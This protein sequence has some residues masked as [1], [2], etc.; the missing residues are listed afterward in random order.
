[1]S[2][3]A[4]W[5]GWA[6][7]AR[8]TPG[9]LQ[10]ASLAGLP[11]LRQSFGDSS[12]LL[13]EVAF[14]AD[15]AAD[16][17]TWT[18]AD[19]TSDVMFAGNGV[20]ISPMGRGDETSASQP[21]GCRFQLFNDSGAYGTGAAGRHYPYVRRNTPVRVRVT[22]DGSSWYTRFQG[23][24]NGFTPSWD[25]SARVAVVSVSASGILRRLQQ[26][27][28]PLQS[29]IARTVL[30]NLTADT[31][32]E[33]W[34]CEE[35]GQPNSFAS[36]M[37]GGPS[38]TYSGS[39]TF[40]NFDDIPGS[41]PLPT[42]GAASAL[43]V[44]VRPRTSNGTLS[45]RCVMSIPS[46]GLINGT[47]FLDIYVSGSTVA[48]WTLQYFDGAFALQAISTT[49]SSLGDTGFIDF[50][51]AGATFEFDL[52]LVQNGSNVETHMLVWK[53]NTDGSIATA[54][55]FWNQTFNSVT[56]GVPTR[57]VAGAGGTLNTASIGHI[58]IA[59]STAIAFG[60]ARAVLA[61]YAGET[62]TARLARLCGE[63][64][65]PIAITG[66]SDISMGAQGTAT[67]V[68]L[69]RDCEKADDGVLYD[70]RSSGLNYVA[71]TSRYN[72][73]A[74]VTADMAASPPQVAAPFSPVDDDQRNRNKVTVK[75]DGGSQATF[76]DSD[77][78]LGTASIGT[79][80]SSVNVNV[81]DD[82][83]LYQRAAH[84][85][86]KGTVEGLR[87]PTLNLDLAGAPAVAPSWLTAEPLARVDVTNI[88]SRATQHP[89]GDV[90]L[91]LEGWSE[92]IHPFAWKATGNCSSGEPWTVLALDGVHDRLADA[93]NSTLTTAIDS[94]STSLSVT[95]PAGVALWSTDAAD[96]PS[97]ADIEGER[98]T[99]TAVSGS[100]SP[101]T[102][103]VTRSANGVVKVHPASAVIT[104]VDAFAP[105]L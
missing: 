67:F 21:A 40:A 2:V 95:T 33:Y 39:V 28:S 43:E 82:T 99:V 94:T 98:V 53:I 16:S 54:G 100:T 88:T 74:T 46:A 15:L 8:N 38:L 51:V 77:G 97:T 10:G 52:D 90:T 20:S 32:G 23:Y 93:A 78:T 34:P 75:R 76:E 31:L 66:T 85:V 102:F 96:Y 87:Y 57:F 4:R 12:R 41:T 73:P 86:R 89:P 3:A 42:L 65:V 6:Q 5:A 45:F 22:I 47:N 25:T 71:R 11:F 58:V 63:E 36:G 79:Y 72:S 27:E 7:R 60:S 91:A 80:D 26:G 68:N 14:G 37:P 81:E 56:V 30:T 9:P 18:W 17:A 13:V 55:N 49:G 50:V 64:G 59:N 48:R 62:A 70:G 1:M 19:V 35:T 29:P 44:T 104:V 61:G 84:E 101:Q 105:S 24:V 103:T 69:L 83:G 92:Q